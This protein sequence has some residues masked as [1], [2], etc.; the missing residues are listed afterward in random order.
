MTREIVHWVSGGVLA[1]AGATLVGAGFVLL[2]GLIRDAFSPRTD[3]DDREISRAV[4]VV[5]VLGGAAVAFLLTSCAPLTSTRKGVVPSGPDPVSD[6]AGVASGASQAVAASPVT[7]SYTIPRW[8]AAVG[9]CDVPATP[10]QIAANVDSV[11]IIGWRRMPHPFDLAAWVAAQQSG[12][13][14]P[15]V[16]RTKAIVNRDGQADT[17]RVPAGYEVGLTVS[18][19]SHNARGWSCISNLTRG[20]TP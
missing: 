2:A 11:R 4:L 9:G 10:Y 1:L 13:N 6:R 19:Q 8:Q 5:V 7:L 16:I 14:L 20:V 15:V 12:Y 18:A 3:P 17:M